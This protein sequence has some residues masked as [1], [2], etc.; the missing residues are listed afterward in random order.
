MAASSNLS[1]L[2]NKDL[3]KAADQILS[4]MKKWLTRLETSPLIGFL[5][6]HQ[7]NVDD[8]MGAVRDSEGKGE[9]SAPPEHVPIDQIDKILTLGRQMAVAAL[10]VREEIK[11]RINDDA[12]EMSEEA[13][14][15]LNEA[16]DQIDEARDD[17]EQNVTGISDLYANQIS[18]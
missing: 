7:L 9:L 3:A 18:V 1:T 17:I 5:L 15:I 14:D 10:G 4:S 2:S 11:S 6:A 16:I 13:A 8:P 12:N